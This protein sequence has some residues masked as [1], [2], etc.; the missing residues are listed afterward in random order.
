MASRLRI[1]GVILIIVGLVSWGAAGYAYL[2][3]QDGQNALQGFSD[4]QDVALTY[5][6][7]GQL[8]DRGSTEEADAILA[9]LGDDWGWPIV[10][11]ELDPN[12]PVTNTATEYMYQM[13]TIA[14]HTLTGVQTVTLPERVEWDGDGD[15]SVV[16]APDISPA[17]LPDA[18]WDPS[19]AGEDAIFEPGTYQVPVAGRYWTGFNRTHPL[20]GPARELAWSGTVHGLFAELGVGATT[21]SSLQLSLGVVAITALMGLGFVIAGGGLLWAS[22]GRK[23]DD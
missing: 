20:D 3:V 4:A 14:H 15:G 23:K 10:D 16:G 1:I 12:D 19:T 5:N 7:Q 21:A 13:A 22:A 2:K 17:S 9:L 6:D 8:T 18:T 11:A